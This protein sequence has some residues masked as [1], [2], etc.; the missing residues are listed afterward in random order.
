MLTDPTD[1]LG[2]LIAVLVIGQVA[3]GSFAH[4]IPAPAR[5]DARNAYFPTLFRK[6]PVRLTHI[7]LGIAI[8][9]L[10]FGQIRLGF[11]EYTKYSDG[12][13]AIPSWVSILF[14]VLVILSVVAYGGGW[15]LEAF[16]RTRGAIYN[17]TGM[18]KFGSVDNTELLYRG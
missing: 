18:A 17:A 8:T 2:I 1:S 14:Y 13:Y 7:F 12:G 5:E 9:V 11:S 10:A 4:R 16:G 15:L 3:L 6:H